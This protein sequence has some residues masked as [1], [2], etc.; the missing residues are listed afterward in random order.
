MNIKFEAKIINQ[1]TGEIMKQVSAV[2]KT[3]RVINNKV[4]K[5]KMLNSIEKDEYIAIYAD[6]KVLCDCFAFGLQ[7][8]SCSTTKRLYKEAI[9]C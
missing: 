2:G 9:Q 8:Y 3:A 6:D 4:N 5:D 1:K 7:D